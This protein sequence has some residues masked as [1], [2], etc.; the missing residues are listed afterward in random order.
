[1]HAHGVEVLD[2]A[3]DHAVVLLVAH[4]LHLDFLPAQHALLDH[5][6][7]RGAGGKAAR[8]HFLQILQI[9]GHAAAR[10]AQGKGRA[11]NQR[12]G[13]HVAQAA[14]VVHIAGNAAGGHFQA[15]VFHG[16]AEELAA[17]GLFNDLGARADEFHPAFRQNAALGKS[18]SGVQCRLAAQGGQEGVRPFLA[19]DGRQSVLFDGL[20]VGGVG[21]LRIGHDGCRV[22]V[23]Q[24]H[25][26]AFFLEGLD[27]LGAGV[28]ELAALADDD[29]TRADNQNFV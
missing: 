15:D 4:D 1:M 6:L 19:D 5:D 29:G 7:R 25:L 13:Q 20:H 18:K 27:G 17:F 24:H 21:H 11:Y 28:V 14:H 22:G 26:I 23:D 9:V 12:E 10:A 8:G 2:G 16:L 3:D